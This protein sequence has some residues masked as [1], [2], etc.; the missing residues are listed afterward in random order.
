MHGQ[1]TAIRIKLDQKGCYEFAFPY[2][3][4]KG[5]NGEMMPITA[6]WG[7]VVPGDDQYAPFAAYELNDGQRTRLDFTLVRTA[8]VTGQVLAADGKTPVEGASVAARPAEREDDGRGAVSNISFLLPSYVFR[9]RALSPEDAAYRLKWGG[10][11]SI[12]SAPEKFGDKYYV[13]NFIAYSAVTDKQGAFSIFVNPLMVYK[14]EAKMYETSGKD[15][16]RTVI[17]A[18]PE[19]KQPHVRLLAG[20]RQGSVKLVL[21]PTTPEGVK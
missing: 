20:R 3:G 11:G 16:T 6:Y 14:V 5:D 9:C 7:L 18:V 12:S 13:I 15:N 10:V 4:R 21:Q 19:E 17:A 1:T 8:V 2:G